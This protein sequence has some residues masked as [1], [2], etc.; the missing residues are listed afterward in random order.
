MCYE[1]LASGTERVYTFFLILSRLRFFN[2]ILGPGGYFFLLLISRFF[3][4]FIL[5]IFKCKYNFPSFQSY[6]H[7]YIETPYLV[8]F[9]ERAVFYHRTRGRPDVRIIPYQAHLRKEHDLN[10]IER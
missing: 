8:F 3:L 1:T 6:T 4:L 10:R 5:L 9:I 7:L 2:G